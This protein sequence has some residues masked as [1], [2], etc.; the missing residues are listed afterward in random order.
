M[1]KKMI[2]KKKQFDN[3]VVLNV[4]KNN[5]IKRSKIK[6]KEDEEKRKRGEERKTIDV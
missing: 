4:T 2:K 6:K 5:G 3:D 1:T